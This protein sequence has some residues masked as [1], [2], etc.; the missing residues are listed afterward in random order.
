MNESDADRENVGLVR[1]IVLIV[2]IRSDAREPTGLNRSEEWFEIVTAEDDLP[3]PDLD[4]NHSR[5][6]VVPIRA[7]E[8]RP[9][10]AS[11]APFAIVE[12]HVRGTDVLVKKCSWSAGNFHLTP[13][14]VRGSFHGATDAPLPRP[15]LP[16]GDFPAS[17]AGA[18]PK[19]IR[20]P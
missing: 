10:H 15:R 7:L 20:A 8:V 2:R 11:P 9:W 1:R 12:G 18:E 3:V 4:A 17:A 19:L 16:A 5:I 14:F 13:R 6:G